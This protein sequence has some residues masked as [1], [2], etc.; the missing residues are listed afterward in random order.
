MKTQQFEEIRMLHIM[1]LNEKR[2]HAW[3]C[4]WDC[5]NDESA[6]CRMSC[7]A[8]AVCA[9]DARRVEAYAIGHHR[10]NWAFQVL[11]IDVFAG[12]GLLWVKSA[13]V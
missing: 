11:R 6:G 7:A 5:L 8:C 4:L 3:K 2:L 1:N 9:L 10:N 13:P 12:G